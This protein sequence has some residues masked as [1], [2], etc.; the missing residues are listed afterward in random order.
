[1]TEAWAKAKAYPR[2]ML[3][4]LHQ[5]CWWRRRVF[6]CAAD[7]VW[8]LCVCVWGGSFYFF[9][10]IPIRGIRWG[11][12]GWI[13]CIF[14]WKRLKH[15]NAIKW[16]TKL[17]KIIF[18]WVPFCCSQHS[19]PIFAGL[20]SDGGVFVFLVCLC[21]CVCVGNVWQEDF[22]DC[23]FTDCWLWCVRM[24]QL[25]FRK[26][27]PWQKQYFFIQKIAFWNEIG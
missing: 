9:L 4:A 25:I 12:D 15:Q 3:S 18:S 14:A 17:C 27:M 24:R 13:E 20:L 6:E 22:L 7:A 23:D 1:M 2:L 16:Y 26:G 11:G 8:L 5:V 10:W 21:V 19:A